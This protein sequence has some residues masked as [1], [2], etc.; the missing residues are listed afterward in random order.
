MGLGGKEAIQHSGCCVKAGEASNVFVWICGEG[1]HTRHWDDVSG[2][3]VV[4]CD[5]CMKRNTHTHTLFIWQGSHIRW[6]KI[7]YTN[8]QSEIAKN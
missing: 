6:K 7:V 5:L 1:R 8:F 4:L 3:S 2:A